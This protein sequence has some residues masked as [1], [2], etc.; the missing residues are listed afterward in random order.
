[1]PE[2]PTS[3]LAGAKRWFVRNVYADH[4]DAKAVRDELARLLAVLDTPGTVGVNVG[5]GTTRLHPRITN[6][7]LAP[8]ENV[9]VVADATR[10][11][12]DDGSVDL[13]GS[14]EAIEHVADPFRAV[15]EMARV[16]KPGALAYVQVP[17][18]I[19][20]HPG[21]T[22]FWRFTV[23][24]IRRLVEQAGLEVVRV[25][26]SVGPA[27]GLY[28]IAVE[29][30]PSAA[31]AISPRAYLPV[32]GASALALSPLKWLDGLLASSPQIDRIAGGYFVVARKP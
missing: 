27:T 21:P 31:A 26:P 7:D 14:Q 5:S 4:N 32:K 10:L 25:A 1:M 6:V 23:E 28:R 22:D 16:L 18:V 19:G 24:G 17:F 29:L 3:L 13:V 2:S 12:F 8:H 9:D 30:L 20:Y 11:P 15:A